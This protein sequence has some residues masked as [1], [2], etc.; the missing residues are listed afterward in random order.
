M[1][2]ALRERSSVLLRHVADEPDSSYN[3]LRR[4]AWMATPVITL[5]AVGRVS[6]STGTI[7]SLRTRERRPVRMLGNCLTSPATILGVPSATGAGIR[8]DKEFW[9]TWRD[10]LGAHRCGCGRAG[11]VHRRGRDRLADED[12]GRSSVVDVSLKALGRHDV[13]QPGLRAAA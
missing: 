11:S 1:W 7:S 4:S 13:N 8:H 9:Y 10:R 6:R 12:V 5:N 2:G 3:A